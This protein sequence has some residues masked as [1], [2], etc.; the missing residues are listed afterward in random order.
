MLPY[1][2]ELMKLIFS[3]E[4]VLDIVLQ[5]VRQE[6]PRACLNTAEV[7]GYGNFTEVS[8]SYVPIEE[9]DPEARVV[10]EVGS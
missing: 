10:F 6:F 7:E 4:E 8:V 9:A 2:K 1:L 5:H 3:K